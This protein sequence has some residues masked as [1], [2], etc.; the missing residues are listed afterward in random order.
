MLAFPWRS[1]SELF[2]FQEEPI[3]EIEAAHRECRGLLQ[4][5]IP[6]MA[7]Y[8][9]RDM[10]NPPAEDDP[11][12][13]AWWVVANFVQENRTSDFL[14]MT[15]LTSRLSQLCGV[16]RELLMYAQMHAARADDDYIPSDEDPID[17]DDDDDDADQWSKHQYYFSFPGCVVVVVA[18]LTRV[19][20][21]DHGCTWL[22]NEDFSAQI[23]HV[24]HVDLHSYSYGFM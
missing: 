13:F 19:E 5:L 23:L 10:T 1:F 3:L 9:S 21:T 18:K 17:D 12:A 2:L 4:P 8:S 24:V 11:T 22:G 7:M 14:L 6:I 20:V 16:L 15:S